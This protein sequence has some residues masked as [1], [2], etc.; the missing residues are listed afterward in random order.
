MTVPLT[1]IDD[2]LLAGTPLSFIEVLLVHETRRCRRVTA[3]SELARSRNPSGPM[4]VA[5]TIGDDA[6]THHMRGSET[7][8]NQRPSSPHDKRH[9]RVGARHGLACAR[10]SSEQVPNE[11]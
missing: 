11:R 9:Y 2:L 4:G 7:E 8:P 10:D 5:M 3:R 6:H 1:L